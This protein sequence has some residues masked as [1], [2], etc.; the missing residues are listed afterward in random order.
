MARRA[1]A[2][3]LTCLSS[4]IRTS[5]MARDCVR[6]TVATIRTLKSR[7]V[8]PREREREREREL[9]EQKV[10]SVLEQVSRE[11]AVLIYLPRIKDLGSN[12]KNVQLRKERVE[13]EFQRQTSERE[14]ERVEE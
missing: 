10:P 1:T 14:R 8:R 6:T 7:L 5:S 13:S 12:C 3:P 11:S 2:G 9:T 4:G